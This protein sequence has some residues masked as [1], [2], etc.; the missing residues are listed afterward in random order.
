MDTVMDLTVYGDEELLTGASALINS[1]DA[2]LSVTN[3]NS[4]IYA[5]NSGKT[6][7]VS[8]ETAELISFALSICKKTGGALEISIYPI[9][10]AFG[11]TTGEYRVPA[12]GEVAE[13]LQAV[14]Y[15]K[16]SLEGETV[17]IPENMLIDLGSVAK[18]FTGDKVLEYLKENGVESALINLGGNVQTLGAKP[19]GS[20][21][22]VAIAD[23]SGDGGYAGAIEIANKCM[24]TSGNYERFFEQDGKRYHH[25]ID[26]KTGYPADNG[27]VSVTVVGESGALCD[28]LSTALF[29]MG[30]EAAA[31]FYKTGGDFEAVL[32]KED[33]S[34][35]VTEGLKAAFTPLGR[36]KDAKVTVITHD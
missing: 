12:A 6:A 3:E 27:L 30:P 20:A 1:L 9:V 33:G 23:P 19:D 31:E 22:K 26:P 5:V 4:D 7:A 29:V 18:G 34:V 24:I 35:L 13:L 8:K 36:Y 16:I 2:K 32:I 14:D 28:A 21:W 11:F 17:T 15:T 10:R 25:I